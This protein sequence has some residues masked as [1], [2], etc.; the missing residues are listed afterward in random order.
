MKQNRVERITLSG[1]LIGFLSSNPRRALENKLQEFNSQ[2][3]HVVQVMDDSSGNLITTIVRLFFLI[4]TVLLWSP[5]N[6][7]F[8]ILEKNE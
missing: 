7:Y 6:G 8:V 5:A 4:I 1:G 3:W 2:G